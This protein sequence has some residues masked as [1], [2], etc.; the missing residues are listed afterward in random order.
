MKL[1]FAVLI[2]GVLSDPTRFLVQTAVNINPHDPN[3]LLQVSPSEL[4]R[5][6]AKTAA[7]KKKFLE[8]MQKLK[9]DEAHF[10]EEK[11][12][13]AQKAKEYAEKAEAD[14]HHN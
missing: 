6:E 13:Y 7:S 14:L 9:K 12:E 3:S 11:Q 10:Y 5:L 8:A 4:Q 1:A 2:G